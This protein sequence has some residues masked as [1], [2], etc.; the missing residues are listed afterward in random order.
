MIIEP[1]RWY[2]TT[3]T[4]MKRVSSDT[5]TLRI[6]RPSGYEFR[7][8]QYAVVRTYVS[9]ERFL[10][11]QYS[12]S[13]PPSADWIEFTIQHEPDG[14]VTSWLDEHARKGTMLEI[15]QSFGNFTYEPSPRPLLFI[16]GR[17]GIAPF[18]SY[19]REHSDKNVHVVYSVNTREQACFW[20]ELAPITTLVVTSE[21]NRIDQ[22]LLASHITNKPIVYIC[23][24]R[25]F[26]E[27][28]QQHLSQLGVTP[29][30]IKRELFTL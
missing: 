26:A 27:S 23:G 11:R 12:F 15:S 28:M 17:V 2:R 25:Q 8:G 6:E 3:V 13:S 9:K 10:V 14:E 4:E 5:F 18:M 19:L 7:A 24:S 16:A 29:S 1:Y 30:D 22:S 21:Q 20:D